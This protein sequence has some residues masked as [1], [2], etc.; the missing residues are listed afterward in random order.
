MSARFMTCAPD[1]L[2]DENARRDAAAAVGFLTHTLLP[3]LR[4]SRIAAESS[5][6]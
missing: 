5:S 1:S 2:A 3:R 4:P 6:S